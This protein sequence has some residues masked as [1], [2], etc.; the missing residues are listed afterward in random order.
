LLAVEY[1]IKDDKNAFNKVEKQICEIAKLIDICW[2]WVKESISHFTLDTDK[3][4][5]LLYSYI[6][7]GYLLANIN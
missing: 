3:T 2:I 4:D 6:L 7:A 1:E 5:W